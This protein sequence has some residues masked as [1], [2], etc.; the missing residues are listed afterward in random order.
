VLVTFVLINFFLIVMLMVTVYSYL[1]NYKK[2]RKYLNDRQFI[3]SS[4][5]LYMISDIISLFVRQSHAELS[6][7]NRYL[8]SYWIVQWQSEKKSHI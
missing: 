2:R 4:L 1:I 6:L 8:Y 3:V 5:R 7:S